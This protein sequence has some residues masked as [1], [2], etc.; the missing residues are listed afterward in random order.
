MGITRFATLMA[1]GDYVI[2][3]TLAPSMIK[4]KILAQKFILQLFFFD[5]PC[6][7]YNPP[8]KL[9]YLFESFVFVIGTCFFATNAPGAVHDQFF[10]LFVLG[11]IL[12]NNIQRISKGIYI[13]GNR[14]FEM[15]YLAFVMIAHID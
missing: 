5:L 6:I 11:Q 2:G 12:F 10:I 13:W 9:I 4:D 7:V 15:P 3:N 14:I 1:L 8:L